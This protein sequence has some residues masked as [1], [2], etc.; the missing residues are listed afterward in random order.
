MEGIEI[1]GWIVGTTW[2]LLWLVGL[3]AAGGRG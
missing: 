3:D 2:S 1:Q